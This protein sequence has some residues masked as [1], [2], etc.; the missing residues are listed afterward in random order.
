MH[1]AK[2]LVHQAIR[3]GIFND[4]GSGSNVDLCIIT[5]DGVQMLR[6]FDVANPRPVKRVYDFPMGSTPIWRD[7]SKAVVVEDAA[8]EM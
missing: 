5:K 4:L 1:E 8:M 7:L 2:H 3:A 6:N